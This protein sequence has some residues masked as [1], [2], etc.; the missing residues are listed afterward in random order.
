MKLQLF[1]YQIDDVDVLELIKLL[2]NL[3]AIDCALL[4]KLIS[5]DYLFEIPNFEV[6][7]QLKQRIVDVGQLLLLL[8]FSPLLLGRQ[9][10]IL[11]V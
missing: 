3:L 8:H 1:T 2:I 9:G 5:R 10:V 6:E 11:L 4:L 7:V